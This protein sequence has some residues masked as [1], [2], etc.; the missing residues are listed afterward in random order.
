MRDKDCIFLPTIN[1]PSQQPL[2]GWNISIPQCYYSFLTWQHSVRTASWCVQVPS[3]CSGRETFNAAPKS[4]AITWGVSKRGQ[5]PLWHH[6]GEF[7]ELWSWRTLSKKC[8]VKAKEDSQYCLK[9]WSKLCVMQ[10]A[11]YFNRRLH[12]SRL[13]LLSIKTWTFPTMTLFT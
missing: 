6:H 10:T 2:R 13:M 12:K 1:N 3:V 7:L 4:S 9:P 11:S 8:P 5:C